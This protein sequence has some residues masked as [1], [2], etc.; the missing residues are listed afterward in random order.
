MAIVGWLLGFLLN[1]TVVKA[2]RSGV[3]LKFLCRCL[4]ADLIRLDPALFFKLVE[5][6]HFKIFVM[7][8][9]R[10]WIFMHLWKPYRVSFRN[11][12]HYNFFTII[13]YY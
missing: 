1:C 4:I 9:V 8:V 7:A 2:V 6:L 10:L 5:F 11:F 12:V 3:R 13:S